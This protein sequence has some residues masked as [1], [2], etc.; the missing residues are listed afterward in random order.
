[1]AQLMLSGEQVLVAGPADDV[2]CQEH[3]PPGHVPYP[4]RHHTLYEAHTDHLQS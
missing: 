4:I 1:M 3:L 2:S